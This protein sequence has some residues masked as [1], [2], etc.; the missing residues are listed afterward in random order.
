MTDIVVST[1]FGAFTTRLTIRDGILVER[2][3][4]FETFGYGTTAVGLGSGGSADEPVR[5]TTTVTTAYDAATGIELSETT[6]TS[7]GD[8]S[9]RTPLDRVT[10]SVERLDVDGTQ[11]WSRIVEHRDAG[12]VPLHSE[13]YGDDGIVSVETY[14]WGGDLASV[15]MVDTAD[16]E[17]W[18]ERVV[19]PG[20]AGG[21]TV[22]YTLG[23]DLLYEGIEEGPFGSGRF[24]IDFGDVM[25]WASLYTYR[26]ADGVVTQKGREGD[27][28]V[29]RLEVFDDGVLASRELLD[30]SDVKAWESIAVFFE[31]GVETGRLTTR[32]D[33]M[34]VEVARD[35]EGRTV[36]RTDA[37]DAFVW[38]ERTDRYDADGMLAEAIR[39]DDDGIETVRSYEDGVLREVVRTDHDDVRDWAEVTTTYDADGVLLER[40]V[41]A[42]DP[43][44]V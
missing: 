22:T 44:A 24:Q 3:E 14:G 36:T 8:V 23:D 17:D 26:D 41:V 1:G 40:I 39:T 37:G 19:L 27:D 12:G 43:L 13:V 30:Q 7:T 15:R 5:T 4:T 2:A 6:E 42:D 25:P 11:P 20:G 38:A 35:A 21:A 31:D 10:D 28:G 34:R 16:T 18:I 32:D 9:V 29:A 33:G